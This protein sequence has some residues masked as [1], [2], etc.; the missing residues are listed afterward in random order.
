MKKIKNIVA[1]LMLAAF[2]FMGTGTV[3]AAS[4]SSSPSV[5]V[6]AAASVKKY[7]LPDKSGRDFLLKGNAWY[8]TDSEGQALTGLQYLPAGKAGKTSFSAGYYYFSKEGKLCTKADFHKLDT[9]VNGKRFRGTYYFG[10]SNGSLYTKR[11]WITIG[12]QKYYLSSS[13]R[14]YQDCWKSGYYLLSN[15]RIAKNQQ[16]PDGSYVDCDGRKCAKEEMALSS[17]KKSLESMTKKYPGTWSVYV[18]NLKTG[19]I[20]NL[21]EKTMYPASTIKAF[22][23]A[24]IYDQINSGKLSYSSAIK[25]LLKQMITVSDNESCNQLVRYHSKSRSFISG[26]GEVNKYLKKNGYTGTEI[27]HTLSPSSSAYTSDGKSNM[28]S[29]KDCGVLLEKIYKGTCVS[30]KYSKEMLNLLLGQTR[31]WKIPA[32]LPSGVKVANKTGE[33]SAVQ[34]DMAI[35]YGKKTDYIICVFSSGAGESS[36]ISGI[37]SISRKV[38]E[39]LNP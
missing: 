36:G 18:K 33:T 1:V 29:A 26:A 25:N 24:S 16:V 28:G 34:H 38:Y 5:S 12:K 21:N 10:G 9:K 37:R 35:V 20:I 4:G 3:Q 32:G 15:G 27:H 2:V 6:K 13:G 8:L 7:S 30:K 39:Y 19:D 23:M 22:V 11:G 17:L 31:R 14:R